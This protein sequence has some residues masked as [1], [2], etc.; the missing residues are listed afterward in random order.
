VEEFFFIPYDKFSN[1]FG[2][3]YNI[4]K[5]INHIIPENLKENMIVIA[6]K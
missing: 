6:K 2:A 1:P 4:R 5:V 3:F